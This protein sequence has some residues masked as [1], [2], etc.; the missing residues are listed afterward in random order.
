MQIIQEGANAAR[1]ALIFFYVKF[2]CLCLAMV[3]LID[4]IFYYDFILFVLCGFVWVPQIVKNA[5]LK[6]RNVPD[7][8][9]VISMAMT[10]C[11]LP[12]YLRGCPNNQF[13]AEP[14]MVWSICFFFAI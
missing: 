10:Q 13:L 6:A 7:S 14:N 5:I 4:I 2:Y 1:R 11:L 9:F 3:I 8:K 12:L